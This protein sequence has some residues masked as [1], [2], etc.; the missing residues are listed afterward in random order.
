MLQILA[1]VEGLLDDPAIQG[2]AAD[3]VASVAKAK[4]DPQDQKDLKDFCALLSTKL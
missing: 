1:F 4:L 3:F 2:P